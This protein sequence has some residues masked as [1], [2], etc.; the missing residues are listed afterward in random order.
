M[1]EELKSKIETIFRNSSS[2]EELFDA[3]DEAIRLKI[4]DVEIY[5]VLL[6]NPALSLDE[7][8]MYA[9]KLIKEFDSRKFQITMWTAEVFENLQSNYDYLESAFNYYVKAIQFNPSSYEPLLG[10]LK[11]YNYEINL[12][13]NQKIIQQIE[14]N[15]PSV[16]LK[17]KVYFELAN[18]YK[19]LGEYKLEAKYI[20]LGEK[21]MENE[22]GDN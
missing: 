22:I 9:E 16:K 17:S 14:Y 5:K 18:L 4:D 6:G 20:A 11:L 12:P 3:F 10:L 15:L 1:I 19:R 7:I 21:A 2:P 8:K 13:I